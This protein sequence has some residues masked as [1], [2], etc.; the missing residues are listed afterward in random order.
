MDVAF[1]LE[2]KNAKDVKTQR[3]IYLNLHHWTDVDFWFEM[4]IVLTSKT[5]HQIYIIFHSIRQMRSNDFFVTDDKIVE[6]GGVILYICIICIP[7]WDP[8]VWM[9]MFY[10]LYDL[11]LILSFTAAAA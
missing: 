10:P 4:K 2:N 1:W 11:Y 6:K 5:Q 8:L 7:P 9:K 3:C